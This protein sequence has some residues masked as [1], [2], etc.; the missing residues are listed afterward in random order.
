MS[1]G[2]SFKHG[3][4]VISTLAQLP[5]TTSAPAVIKAARNTFIKAADDFGAIDKLVKLGIVKED[6]VKLTRDI[7]RSMIGTNITRQMVVD[8]SLEVPAQTWLKVQGVVDKVQ[9]FGSTMINLAEFF[10]RSVSVEAAARMA[11]KKGM[12]AQQSVYGIYD[13]ILSNNFLSREFNASWLK[14]PKMRALLMFQATPFKI[15]ERRAVSAIRTGKTFVEI[16][17]GIKEDPREMLSSLREIRKYVTGAESEFK[18]TMLG[19]A[20]QKETDFFGTPIAN[21]FVKEMMLAGGMTYGAGVGIN[22]ALE[23]HF[24]HL[25]FLD[26]RD[27]RATLSLNPAIQ[28]AQQVYHNRTE[29]SDEFIVTEFM[30]TWLGSGGVVPLSIVRMNRLFEGDIPDIYGTDQL[31]HLRY[32]LTVPAYDTTH[33]K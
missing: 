11:A 12:T 29:N 25:P 19:Q 30:N 2:A 16:A 33:G 26:I 6:A 23:H 21:S 1:P 20:L 31:R 18:A 10:D 9:D 27:Y 22:S 32:F 14:S 8:A 5:V 3:L 4:K 13:Q 28:A 7:S 17:K 15:A 24:F